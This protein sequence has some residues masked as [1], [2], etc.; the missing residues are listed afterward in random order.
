V[1]AALQSRAPC[2]LPSRRTLCTA[3]AYGSH[4]DNKLVDSL[5]HASERGD[6][7]LEGGHAAWG[8]YAQED[9][10]VDDWHDEDRLELPEV[11]VQGEAMPDLAAQPVRE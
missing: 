11:V 9:S 10:G 6:E 3:C 4:N 1:G 7:G 2:T 8:C 5:A